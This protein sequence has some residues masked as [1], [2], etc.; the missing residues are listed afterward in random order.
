MTNLLSRV[1]VS[2]DVLYAC[3]NHAL[4]TEHQ[5]IMGLLLGKYENNEAFVARSMVLN[6]K[7]KKK[8]RVEVII[9]I[10]QS[11]FLSRFNSV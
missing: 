10:F 6:R 4:C 1:I 5:E 7:D 2:P 8:D 9:I 11:V 3:L